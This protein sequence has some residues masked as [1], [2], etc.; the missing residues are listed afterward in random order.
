MSSNDSFNKK[1]DAM[2][3]SIGITLN[4]DTAAERFLS[5]HRKTRDK[6]NG[7]AVKAD[8]YARFAKDLFGIDSGSLETNENQDI[9]PLVEDMLF[10]SLVHGMSHIYPRDNRPKTHHWLPV[11]YM[12]PFGRKGGNGT[13][14]VVDGT[15]FTGHGVLDVTV[16]DIQ[17]AHNRGDGYDLAVEAFFC[18]IETLYSHFRQIRKTS[19]ES[20]VAMAAFFVAQSVRNPHPDAGFVAKDIV[21]V[22]NALMTSLDVNDK[23]FGRFENN[24]HQLPLSP[25]VP[26]KVRRLA[27]GNNVYVLPVLPNV[28]FILSSKSPLS[29]DQALHAMTSYRNNMIK[30]AAKNNGVV[31]GVSSASALKTLEEM[32]S[33]GVAPVEKM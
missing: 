24:N 14:A 25:Y 1:L 29:Q 16:K 5:L 9:K 2:S 18:S 19:K 31:F 6:N 13:R 10:Y 8:L 3:R 32:S 20:V 33:A 15:C 4:G 12:R 27:D 21:G 22:V 26:T 17:F 11:T 28:G 30:D 7:V 23:M